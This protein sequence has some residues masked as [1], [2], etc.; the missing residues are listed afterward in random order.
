ML[1]VLQTMLLLSQML[2]RCSHNVVGIF[3]DA[4]SFVGCTSAKQLS[5]MNQTSFVVSGAEMF[6]NLDEHV[7]VEIGS[8]DAVIVC[9]CIWPLETLDI[10]FCCVR[11]MMKELEPNIVKT[12]TRCF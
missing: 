8:R 6:V 9:R 1:R 10:T 5:A 11:D 2:V 3:V 7:F 4:S 12:S